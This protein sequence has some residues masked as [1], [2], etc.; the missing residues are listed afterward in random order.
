[1]NKFNNL[2][3]KIINEESSSEPEVTFI[4]K[5][6][7]QPYCTIQYKGQEI[8]LWDIEQPAII[9]ILDN[10][11]HRQYEQVTS[12]LKKYLDKFLG[13]NGE[14]V[15]V[16]KFGILSKETLG[17]S[18]DNWNASK[19]PSSQK[20]TPEKPETF[21][22]DDDSIDILRVSMDDNEV[23][24]VL[25]YKGRKFALW[26]IEVPS[27]G[28]EDSDGEEY[29]SAVEKLVKRKNTLIKQSIERFVK[30]QLDTFYIEDVGSLDTDWRNV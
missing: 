3:K 5:D 27:S 29:F 16:P 25:E 9:N 12:F 26:N 21:T 23:C 13:G 19:T 15:Y 22:S 10:P 6:D 30:T 18:I 8:G 28:D 1:M 2:Y 7:G 20:M 4:G 14:S 17:S 11:Q 24:A